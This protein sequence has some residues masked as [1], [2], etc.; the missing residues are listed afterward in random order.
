MPSPFRRTLL[1]AL[2]AGAAPSFAR[3]QG[4]AVDP[5]CPAA[6]PSQ[7]V[8]Q[9]ACQK[10]VDLFNYLAPQL[11][12]VI[13]GG[14]PEPGQGGTL[15]GLGHFGVSVRATGFR[16]PLPQFDRVSVSPNGAQPSAI[17]VQSTLVAF[18]VADVSIGLFAGVPVGV[19]RIGGLDALV[20]ATYVPD[21]T[22]GD[23]RVSTGG[24]SVRVGYGA[25]LG[26]L[27]ESAVVPGIAVSLLRRETPTTAITATTGNDTLGV[28]N[29]RV[30]TDSW[31]LT[32]AKRLLFVSVAAGVGQDRYESTARVAG[33]V[34]DAL[35]G[36]PVRAQA[37]VDLRQRLT[38][39]NVFGNLTLLAIP[40]TRVVAE[41]GRTSGGTL[42]ATYNSIDGRRP[43]AAYTYGS[44]GVRVGR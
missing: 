42:A 28:S 30:R 31:R 17:P 21:V 8:A 11:G 34:N 19:T 41:V 15:G 2:L 39:T 32:A 26:L 20:N 16:S 23:V 27:E 4:A 25:R 5:Q 12:A 36:V 6:T 44:L 40:F 37:S 18:P 13:A 38:R 22:T 7:R 10:S 14:N 35:L 29:T 3:A 43:D 9:D 33:V 1:L 24:G